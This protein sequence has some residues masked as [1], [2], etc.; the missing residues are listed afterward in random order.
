[1]S[2][3]WAISTVCTV[4]PLMSMPRIWLPWRGL[5]RAVG[6]LHAAGL[7]APAVFTC[8]FT[9][10]AGVLDGEVGGDVPP[11]RRVRDLARLHRHAV[12]GEQ[13]FRLYSNRSTG[14]RSRFPIVPPRH[15]RR[16][17]EA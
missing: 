10:Q 5:V 12:L 13:V 6:Q 4:W 15:E 17:P 14:V 1:M 7:A 16:S 8:A 9:K 11:F 3:A 2:T